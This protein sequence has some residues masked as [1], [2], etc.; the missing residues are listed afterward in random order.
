MYEAKNSSLGLGWSEIETAEEDCGLVVRTASERS[1]WEAKFSS[2][3]RVLKLAGWKKLAWW[4]IGLNVIGGGPQRKHREG[5]SGGD[6]F[7]RWGAG[8][9]EKIGLE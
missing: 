2:G 4:D 6:G 7:Q 3:S 8:G 1:I 5:A 9:L